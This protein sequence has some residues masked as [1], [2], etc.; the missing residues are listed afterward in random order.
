[1]EIISYLII[2]FCSLLAPSEPYKNIG[3]KIGYIKNGQYTVTL[4]TISYKAFLENEILD[5]PGA[6]LKNFEILKS[7]TVGD[8]KEEYYMLIAY[9]NDLNLKSTRWLIKEND[10]LHFFENK[11]GR[12]IPN[13]I[14]YNTY[15][16]CYGSESNC[17]PLVRHF[18]DGYS[19]G[20]SEERACKSSS[21]CMASSTLIS[22]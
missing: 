19:W 3:E 11:T 7:Q 13:Q 5:I 17:F 21:S 8:Y 2:S 14:F 16:T 20:T 1:M 15:Y 6:N 22:N 12:D 18:K 4:D 9:D 10:N